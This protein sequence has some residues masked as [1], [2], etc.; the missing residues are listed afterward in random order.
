MKIENGFNDLTNSDYC[1]EDG[2]LQMYWFDAF[3]KNGKVFIFGKVSSF[4]VH[5]W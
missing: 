5:S 1:E 2:S 3:E 4:I